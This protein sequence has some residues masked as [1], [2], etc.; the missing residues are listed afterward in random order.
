MIAHPPH[1]CP[2]CGWA[3][4]AEGRAMCFE[5]MEAQLRKN[6]A[7]KREWDEY[8]PPTDDYRGI[9]GYAMTRADHAE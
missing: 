3:Y 4:K 7:K 1:I 5:C 9:Y 2:A 8:E 6:A